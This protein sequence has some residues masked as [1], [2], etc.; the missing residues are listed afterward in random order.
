M[1]IAVRPT[2]P[3]IRSFAPATRVRFGR[4]EAIQSNI[5]AKEIGNVIE[6]HILRLVSSWRD[7]MM[8]MWAGGWNIP[9][10]DTDQRSTQ[11][12][13]HN[14]EEM[15]EHPERLLTIASPTSSD[16]LLTRSTI[17]ETHVPPLELPTSLQLHDPKQPRQ[18]NLQ[19]D[20]LGL[21]L[22]TEV[23]GELH[24]GLLPYQLYPGQD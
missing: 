15:I 12:S 4:G 2:S 10:N 17:T 19:S 11:T 18:Y 20:G 24:S 8:S 16:W 23:T 6:E 5:K 13:D 9:T 14:I 3:E 22:V 21:T 7:E 1:P